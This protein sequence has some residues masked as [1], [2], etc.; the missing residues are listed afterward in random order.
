MSALTYLD[1][2]NL[3]SFKPSLVFSAKGAS[4]MRLGGICKTLLPVSF[5][6]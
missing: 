2:Q 4:K 6:Q 3:D 5:L 1:S